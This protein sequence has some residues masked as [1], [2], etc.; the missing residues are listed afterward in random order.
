MRPLLIPYDRALLYNR[1][2]RLPESIVVKYTEEEAEYLSLRPVVQQRFRG[3][4][5]IDMVVSVTGKDL[6]RI[7]R[8]LRSGTVVFHSYR[9][10][11]RGFEADASALRKVLAGYPDPDFSRPFRTEDCR[12]VILESGRAGSPAVHFRR[13]PASKRRFLRSHSL[14]DCLMRY[15]QE[16]TPKYREYSYAA[17]ADLYA[18]SVDG[19]QMLRIVEEARRYAT[20]AVSKQK[21]EARSFSEI[22]YVCPRDKEV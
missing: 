5:L 6:T 17:S 20:R 11:W 7:Q 8:I 16:A 18:A 12:E 3:S 19:E 14:W 1:V 22:V 4:E 21:L 9:Y 15:A 2:V 10:W 13:E